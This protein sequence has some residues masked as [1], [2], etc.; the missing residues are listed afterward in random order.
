[1]EETALWASVE[2]ESF[3]EWWEPFT[4]GVGPAGGHFAKLTP[5]RQQA[6][7]QRARGLLPAAAFTITARAWAAR[8]TA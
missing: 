4:F 7:E 5:D 3:E 1:M 2:H 8:G 6:L